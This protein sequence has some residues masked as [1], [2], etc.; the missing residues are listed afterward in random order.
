MDVLLTATV[1]VASI[2]L[3]VVVVAGSPRS[4]ANLL[5]I[6][7]GEHLYAPFFYSAF[8]TSVWLWLYAASVLLSRA[9]LRMNKS[10]GFLLRVTDVEKQ[11]FRSMGFVSVI[12][13]SGLFALG[14]PFVLL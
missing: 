14:L 10:V 4:E 8:F 3:A 2:Y 9:L 12:V 7:R 11:P 13:A 1:S 6:L 5:E